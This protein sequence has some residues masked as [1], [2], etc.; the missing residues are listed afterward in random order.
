MG[1]LRA[2]SVGGRNRT[3]HY[4]TA[5]ARS[6]HSFVVGGQCM[7]YMYCVQWKP[8]LVRSDTSSYGSSDVTMLQLLLHLQD[9]AR[10]QGQACTCAQCRVTLLLLCAAVHMHT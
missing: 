4:A 8:V 5:T 1:R 3:V 7:Q 9:C 10:Y 6:L 2:L